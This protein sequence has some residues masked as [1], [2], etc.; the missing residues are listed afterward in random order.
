MTQYEYKVVTCE[1]YS[2]IENIVSGE[3]KL[4]WDLH[5]M[6]PINETGESRKYVIIFKRLKNAQLLTD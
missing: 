4:G 6:T 5:T 2:N 3:T 1:T